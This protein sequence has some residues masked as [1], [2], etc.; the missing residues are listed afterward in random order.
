MRGAIVRM[1]LRN[2]VTYDRCEFW[3]GPHLNMIIGP[4]GTG[5]STI[6]CAMALG[7][8]GSTSLLGR[9]KELAD[10]VKHGHDKAVIEVELYRS[11]EEGN[12]VIRRQ[13]KQS[14]NTSIWKINGEVA[15]QKDVLKIVNEL[16]IQVD[17][18]CQFLPQDR[19]SEFAQL[20]SPELLVETQKAAGRQELSEAHAQLIADRREEKQ[21]AVNV[22]QDAAAIEQLIK[23]N[24]VLERDVIR[25]QER[26]S[27]LKR[28]ED[29]E[30]SLPIARY[31]GTKKE[32]ALA[33]EARKAAFEEHN[34]IKEE[35]APFYEQQKQFEEKI[36]TLEHQQKQAVEKFTQIQRK[37]E[38]IL[39]KIDDLVKEGDASRSGLKDIRQREKQR[40]NRINE[41]EEHIQVM[42]EQLPPAPLASDIN[43]VDEPLRLNR[44]KIADLQEQLED[45]KQQQR[46]I[47]KLIRRADRS[48]YEAY[49]WL[50]NNKRLFNEDVYGPIGLE[51][52]LKHKKY[53]KA[54]EAAIGFQVMKLFVCSCK[55]DYDLF[56]RELIDRQRLRVSVVYF[57]HK[58]DRYRSPVPQEQL[59][60]WGLETYLINTVEAPEPVAVALCEQSKLHLFPFA[61]QSVN[62]E[63]II[64]SRQ[65]IGYIA[66]NV[67]NVV[68]VSPYGRRQAS[69][70]ASL[71]QEAR[72]LSMS[73]DMDRKQNFLRE[74]DV[75]RQKLEQ[76]ANT[77]RDLITQQHQIQN[78]LHQ[79]EEEKVNI[80]AYHL[81][82]LIEL[83]KNQLQKLLEEPDVFDQQREKLKDNLRK[84]ALQRSKALIDYTAIIK[85]QHQILAERTTATIEHVSE[86]ARL[87][88][89]HKASSLHAE[90]LRAAH[91]AFQ[92]ADSKYSALKAKVKELLDQVKQMAGTMDDETRART[93]EICEAMS[94][95]Q[96]EDALV[97]ERAKADLTHTANP[98]II[99]DYEERRD[100]I[101]EQSE[102]LRRKEIRL[103]ELRTEIENRLELWCPEI[104]ALVQEISVS[105]SAAFKAINCTGEVRLRKHEDYDQWGIDIMVKF[106]DNEELKMLDGQRQSGGER[107]VSTI[108]YLMALQQRA[109]APFRVVDEIN[110]GMDPRNERM[111]HQRLVEVSCQPGT[112]QYFLITPK[113]LPNLTYHK[114]MKVLCI[115]NGE[116]QPEKLY[117]KGYMNQLKHSGTR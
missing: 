10:F 46:R 18:L 78:E 3:P 56:T 82:L 110:Q 20:T 104:T 101:N 23:R 71:I 27:I 24:S 50:C 105:F 52:N 93:R 7:L 39:A 55:S 66:N 1:A 4:N 8:G 68:K 108:L 60:A 100:R 114:M 77:I 35:N 13:I 63:E 51:I 30:K 41:L 65:I 76:N 9:G 91:A 45:K 88:D 14:T 17:N 48:T 36:E 69:V 33:K 43:E 16:N 26:E 106:R 38:T 113:L 37:R 53:A 67:R 112:P 96:I 84:Y 6:V 70:Q 47:Q 5:K 29:L 94:S 31:D 34:R 107:S 92:H 59:N 61:E 117:I 40:I 32:F 87:E 58:L 57:D 2:F 44:D 22:A 79:L 90:S 85:K 89:L 81:R 97:S 103:Q 86:L 109:K 12:V 49:I 111:V 80:N 73:T 99:R 28:I 95:E 75:L 74:S 116:W 115:F 102:L 54:V 21:L 11:P 62:D 19:V 42:E 83:R 25:F 98:S 72:I 64:A 15:S